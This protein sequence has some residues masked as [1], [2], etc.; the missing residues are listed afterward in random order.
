MEA[1]G[2]SIFLHYVEYLLLYLG[3]Y[4]VLVPTGEDVEE[5]KSQIPSLEVS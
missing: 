4:H 3:Y 1:E 5:A 2:L